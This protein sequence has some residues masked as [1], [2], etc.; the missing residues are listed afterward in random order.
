MR[1]SPMLSPALSALM[2]LGY[3]ISL[4]KIRQSLTVEV[5]LMW[6]R[7]HGNKKWPAGNIP[8]EP[9]KTKR[10]PGNTPGGLVSFFCI[11]PSCN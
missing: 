7:S 1:L 6:F 4:T 2:Q 5:V 3:S 9:N 11:P 10:P 8:D